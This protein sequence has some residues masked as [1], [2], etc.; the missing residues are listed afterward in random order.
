VVGWLLVELSSVIFP[1]LML[2]AWTVRLVILLALVGFPIAL[3]LAWAFEL[4]PD[5]KLQ[6]ASPVAAVDIGG[7]VA[8]GIGANTT[9]RRSIA[10][11][12]LENLSNDAEN[13][14]FGDGIAEEVL[15]LLC[16]IS[17][18]SVASRTSSFSFRKAQQQLD[19]RAVARQLDVDFILEGSVRR[20]ANRVRISAQLIDGRADRNLWS[21]V[22]NRELADVFEVQSEIAQNIVRALEIN[23]TPAQARTLDR[24]ATTDNM[25]AYDF[26]LRGRHYFERTDARLA[27]QMFERAIEQDARFAPAWAGA[28]ES[29]A[30]MAMWFSKTPD[31]LRLADEYS[32]TALELAPNSASSVCARGLALSINERY[33]EADAHF[34]RA[35]EIDPNRF[36]S[37]YL[38]GRSEFTQGRYER[39]AE[40]F[41]RA[42]SIRPDDIAAANLVGTA[43]K[44]AGRLDAARKATLRA[45]DV[46]RKY[47]ALNPDDVV[48]TGRGAC[49]L[50]ESGFVEEG[51]RWADRAYAMNPG[52]GGYNVAC[53]YLLAGNN[54]RALDILEAV[55]QSSSLHVDWLENDAD[56]AP[57]RDEPRFKAIIAALKESGSATSAKDS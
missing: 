19:V 34:K 2:P 3:V 26:Y 45:V 46:T 49:V 11:L 12:P 9:G 37:F 41:Q 15:N 10:V 25:V 28:A 47:V 35:I 43:L 48:A 23:L 44:S 14:Y 27:L 54:S 16:K 40:M 17:Q 50:V 57:I 1:Q 55:H 33:T 42:H 52:L 32:R 4:S 5:A 20:A 53:A 22:Y 18:L 13:E 7:T 30:W 36:E 39:A 56:M 21:E 8:P 24:E 51:L 29:C 31:N 6:A 38:A